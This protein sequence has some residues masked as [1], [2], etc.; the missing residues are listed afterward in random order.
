[1]TDTSPFAFEPLA[2]RSAHYYEQLV[3]AEGLPYFNVFWAEPAQAAHDWPDFGDVMSRQ[4]QGAVMMRR[5]T[6]RKAGTED[7]WR[8]KILGYIDPSD[9]LLYRPATSWS[10]READWGDAALTLY[11]LVTDYADGGDAATGR[12]VKAMA[13]G[14]LR[15]ARAGDSPPAAAWGFIVKGL[16]TGA[17]LLD[18]GAARELAGLVVEA[19]FNGDRVFAPDNTFAHGGH[20]H[21]NLRT[22]VGAADWALYTRD[23]VLWGRV[24]A[25]YRWV[26][27]TATRFGF[28]PEQ[29]GR[30]GDIVLCE[31]C[32][33]MDYAGLGVTLASHGH[34]EYW[35]D[36]ERLARNQYAESQVTDGSWLHPDNARPDTAQ[37][38]WRDID[39]RVR[40]AWAGWSSPTHILACRETLGAHWGGPELKGKTRALQNCCGGS[41]VHGLYILWKG[42]ALFDGGVLSVHMHVDKSLPEAEIR[43]MQPWKGALVIRLK[44]GCRVRVRIPEFTRAEDMRVTVNGK[45][46]K[47]IPGGD[48]RPGT[49][50]KTARPWGNYL[51]VDG[52]AAGDLI[53]V[54]YPLVERTEE[55]CIGNPGFR[56]YRYAVTWKGDT[57]VEMKPVGDIPSTGYSD[58]EKKDVPV[59]YGTEGPGPLYQREHM[60]GDAVP[61]PAALHEDDGGL[62]FWCA[63][64]EK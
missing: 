26:R 56:Q 9:A 53:E 55:E 1:M 27:S 40:G 36:M 30:K 8:R 24:D 58:F 31:T 10:R 64:R 15:K 48:A 14:L 23:P 19:V 52:C 13:E 33:L 34:P 46:V 11:A 37:F 6:G 5:M 2:A 61:A 59:F 62:D 4:L 3:D 12:A 7:A 41:G 20:M 51:E 44:K 18:C 60:R 49:S 17:R 22:L 16:V 21:G 35:G 54:R 38:T 43:C 32:A 50:E 25:L 29:A 45:D 47:A 63:P 57:V 42:A 39:T 28:L